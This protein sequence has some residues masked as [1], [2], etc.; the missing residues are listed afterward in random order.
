LQAKEL[1]IAENFLMPQAFAKF[2]GME[3]PSALWISPFN[4]A[5]SDHPS[6]LDKREGSHGVRGCVPQSLPKGEWQIILLSRVCS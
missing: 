1:Q 3:R 2:G 6:F 4:E 5:A